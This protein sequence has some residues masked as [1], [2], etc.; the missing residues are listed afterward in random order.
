[1]D[2]YFL[3][4][5]IDFTASNYEDSLRFR[6][7]FGIRQPG[8]E[9]NE[10]IDKGRVSVKTTRDNLNKYTLETDPILECISRRLLDF[11]FLL[12]DECFITDHN[13]SN[14]SYQFEDKKL[15]LEEEPEV[16]YIRRSR[17][18]KITAVFS[19]RTKDQKSYYNG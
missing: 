9:I 2:S 13:A 19:D 16:D 6:G 11:H 18:A 7:F 17:Y 5:A 8:T 4:E 12:Q 1:M 15:V 14:H 10:L 3:P